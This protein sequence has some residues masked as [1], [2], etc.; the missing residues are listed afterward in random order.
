MKKNLTVFVFCLSVF[1]FGIM[2]SC[3]KETV[4][5]VYTP[6]PPP[7]TP[8][9]PP[10]D[11]SFTEEFVNFYNLEGKGWVVKAYTAMDS[12]GIT[13]WTQGLFGAAIKSDTSFQGFTPYSGETSEYAYSY[14]TSADNSKYFSS[15]LLTP[16]LTVKNGDTISFYTRGDTTGVYTNRMQ[17]LLNTTASVNVGHDVSS[18]GDFTTKIFDINP[19]HAPGGYP[20]SWTRFV[21]IF[22]GLTGQK[23]V[24]IGFRHFEITPGNARG[25]GIDVFR[26]GVK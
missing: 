1:A 19:T 3:K 24:R 11:T 16:I 18:V 7:P 8:P 17:V 10:I 9:L 15:W 13:T 22:S 25:V 21:Y 12:M 14:V 26:F 5:P 23:N 4:A 20:L 6:P 2:H